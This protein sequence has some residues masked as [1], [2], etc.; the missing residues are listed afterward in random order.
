MKVPKEVMAYCP[1]CGKHTLHTVKIYAKKPERW[2]NVGRRRHERAIKG[3]VGSVEPKAHSKKLGKKQ[4]VILT[5]TVC[6]KS[7]ERVLGKRTKK[8]LE[9]KR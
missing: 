2:L 7:V 1:Y 3:H 5:C 8:K 6:H 4:K 9:I